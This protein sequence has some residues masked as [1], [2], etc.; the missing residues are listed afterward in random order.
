MN[1]RVGL[2]RLWVVGSAIWVVGVSYLAFVVE[3]TAVTFFL[4]SIMLGPPV[5]VL[6]LF[7]LLAWVWKGFQKDNG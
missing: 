3:Q 7:G 2:F 1:W 6:L 4:A 5:G